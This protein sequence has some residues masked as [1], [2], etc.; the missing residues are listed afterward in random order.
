MA[1]RFYSVFRTVFV[2]LVIG[3]IVSNSSH[4][5]PTDLYP[6]LTC[7]NNCAVLGSMDDSDGIARHQLTYFCPFH[8][9]P[10]KSLAF[11]TS[12]AH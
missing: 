10:L 8:G 5:K 12:Q 6:M 2:I 7:Q 1:V 11:L 3:A 4:H 9:E